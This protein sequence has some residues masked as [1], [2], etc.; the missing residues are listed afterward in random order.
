VRLTESPIRVS[1]TVHA[2]PSDIVDGLNGNDEATLNFICQ[3]I[4]LS[5]SSDLRL[6]LLE[7]LGIDLKSGHVAR[8]D[9][10]HWQDDDYLPEGTPEATEAA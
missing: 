1:V 2:D 6:E 10:R 5:H 4:A 8:Y 7:R 3:I 9:E